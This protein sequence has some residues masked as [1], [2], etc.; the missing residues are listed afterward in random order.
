MKAAMLSESMDN[1]SVVIIAF[2]NFAKYI[3]KRALQGGKT[4]PSFAVAHSVSLPTP[5][6]RMPPSRDKLKLLERS[7]FI[8]P[9]VGA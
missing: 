4:G 2:K 5:T 9:R 8:Q 3:E 6:G 7:S 1:L